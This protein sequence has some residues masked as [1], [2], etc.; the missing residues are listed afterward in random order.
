MGTAKSPLMFTAQERALIASWS[1]RMRSPDLRI[2][3]V[4]RYRFVNEALVVT[5]G[6]EEEPLWMVH[7]SLRGSVAVRHW[8]GLGQFVPTLAEALAVVE[9]AVGE[10]Q[11]EPTSLIRQ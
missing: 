4:T 9:A 1:E 6:D 7:K 10:P 8:P 11:R 3:I 5:S 2:A